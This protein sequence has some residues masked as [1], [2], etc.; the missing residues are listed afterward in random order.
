MG[1][2]GNVGTRKSRF[3][4]VWLWSRSGYRFG[5]ARGTTDAY[6]DAYAQAARASYAYLFFTAR[7]TR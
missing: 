7:K 1:Q 4:T 2:Q 3:E 6:L 5:N